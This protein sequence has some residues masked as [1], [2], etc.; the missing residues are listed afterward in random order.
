MRSPLGVMVCL[1]VV[2]WL[3]D[4]V[5]CCCPRLQSISMLQAIASVREKVLGPVHIATGEVQYT[6]V[7]RGR[8]TLPLCH[9]D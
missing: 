5:S 6:L 4:G 9:V 3:C 7:R 1:A 8:G 2:C